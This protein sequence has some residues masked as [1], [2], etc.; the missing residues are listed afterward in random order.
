M[1]KYG[2]L[3]ELSN[4]AVSCAALTQALVLHVRD[5]TNH[6]DQAAPALAERARD[7]MAKL[8]FHIHQWNAT[9]KHELRTEL[10]AHGDAHRYVIQRAT[11][12]QLQIHTLAEAHN[13]G[14][15]HRARVYRG[16]VARWS[17]MCN[18]FP[19]GMLA[20]ADL[21]AAGVTHDLEHELNQ[22][23]A[24]VVMQL[25]TKAQQEFQKPGALTIEKVDKIVMMAEE[26][27]AVALKF[28]ADPGP[29]YA[30]IGQV[31]ADAG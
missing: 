18:A 25:T 13:S 30:M 10:T 15:E 31:Y 24:P 6:A 27:A 20:L 11:Q 9:G 17:A 12:L 3:E 14:N 28:N 19:E 7:L 26:A 23:V 4:H 29:A 5:T 21:A 22:A 1:S 16:I 8:R 2:D